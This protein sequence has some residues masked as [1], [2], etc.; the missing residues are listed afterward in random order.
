MRPIHLLLLTVICLAGCGNESGK[1]N[2]AAAAPGKTVEPDSPKDSTAGASQSRG[3]ASATP[4][5][6]DP[7]S[8]GAQEWEAAIAQAGTD[9]KLVAYDFTISLYQKQLFE[10]TIQVPVG[11]RDSVTSGGAALHLPG[12]R[13]ILLYPGSGDFYLAKRAREEKET[14]VFESRDTRLT[15]SAQ[16]PDKAG[17]TTRIELGLADLHAE[18]QRFAGSAEDALLMLHC[19]RTLK[20][21][22]APP[23]DPIKALEFYRWDLTYEGGALF[24]A[25]DDFKLATDRMLALLSGIKTLKTLW[26]TESSVTD[27][28][29]EH[30]SGLDQLEAIVIRSAAFTGS[31]LKALAK[32]PKLNYIE[33]ERAGVTDQGLS[34]LPKFT[35]PID[36]DLSGTSVTDAGFKHLKRFKGLKKFEHTPSDY[37]KKSPRLNGSGL[38]DLAG[39]TGLRML[40]LDGH[41]IT[42]EHLAGLAGLPA[43]TDLRL[44]GSRVTG[45][46]LSNLAALPA[47]DSIE[48]RESPVTDLAHISSIPKLRLLDVSKTQINDASIQ[49]LAIAKGLE[50]L[51]LDDTA[52]T[53]A[54]LDVLAALPALETLSLRNTQVKP[55]DLAKLA[56]SKSLREL[57][58]SGPWVTDAAAPYLARLTQLKTL[59]LE[60]S[61]LTEEGI[62]ILREALPDTQL[63]PPKP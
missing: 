56:A 37:P 7:W 22:Q 13:T 17:F 49:A 43:L 58:I 14:V 18:S 47:L 32:L 40:Q 28:G 57:S 1:D 59:S 52:I 15:R 39:L 21:R 34:E 8:R 24:A 20:L 51:H 44:N 48:L 54:S 2:H 60:G 46:N 50:I 30:L 9:A 62:K 31:G 33:C 38:K 10:V 27:A 53:G 36:L 63:Y 42:D 55:A 4:T 19:L 25:V 23:T 12:D 3:P 5:A 45:K 61:E 16:W 41:P 26:I 29:L 35:Q 6:S 11:T